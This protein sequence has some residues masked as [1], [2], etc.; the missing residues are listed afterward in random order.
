MIITGCKHGA[1]SIEATKAIHEHTNK[2]LL[3]SKRLIERVLD[4]EMV[5]IPDDFVL[6]EDLE[7]HRFTIA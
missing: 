7:Y 2:S 3:E 1:N 6:R 4:G 5:E